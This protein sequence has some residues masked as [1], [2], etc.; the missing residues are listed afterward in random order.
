MRNRQAPGGPTIA[1]IAGERHPD[2][3]AGARRG[4]GLYVEAREPDAKFTDEKRGSRWLS[5]GQRA[6][7]ALKV[8]LLREEPR[9]ACPRGSPAV[10]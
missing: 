6:S 10:A 1:E 3:V 4:S 9:W 8:N 7:P 5:A 2:S